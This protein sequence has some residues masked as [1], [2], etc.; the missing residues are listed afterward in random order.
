[1]VDWLF[2]NQ[3]YLNGCFIRNNTRIFTTS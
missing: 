3:K 1:M 2:T